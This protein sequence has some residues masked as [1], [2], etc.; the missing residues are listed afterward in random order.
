MF[1]DTKR[2]ALFVVLGLAFIVYGA[3]PFVAGFFVGRAS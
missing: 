2:T 1:N 3:I